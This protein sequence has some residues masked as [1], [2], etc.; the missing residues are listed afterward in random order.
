MAALIFVSVFKGP[1]GLYFFVFYFYFIKRLI[2]VLLCILVILEYISRMTQKN[3]RRITFPSIYNILI[4]ISRIDDVRHLG[5]WFID[6]RI[7]L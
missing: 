3:L 5:G 6:N 7:K 4:P 2:Y 1:V